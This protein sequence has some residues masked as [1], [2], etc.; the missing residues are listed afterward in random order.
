MLDNTGRGSQGENWDDEEIPS[1][2]ESKE[3]SS[4]REV[5]S[6]PIFLYNGFF[7][8]VPG[9]GVLQSKTTQGLENERSQ[10]VS[11]I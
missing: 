3:N 10:L 2:A 11:E 8:K 7:F 5:S 4:E 6:R 9:I 1:S